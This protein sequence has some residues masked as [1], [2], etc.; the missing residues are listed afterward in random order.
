[1]FLLNP[2][3]PDEKIRLFALSKVE[4]MYEHEFVSYS[5]QLT[6][7]LVSFETD[8]NPLIDLIIEKSTYEPYTVGQEYLWQFRNRLN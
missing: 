3:L 1:M 8:D 6:Q 5:N 2:K 7:A 4:K